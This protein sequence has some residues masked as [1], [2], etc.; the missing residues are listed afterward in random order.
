MIKLKPI[1][2]QILQEELTVQTYGQLKDIISAIRTKQKVVQMWDTAKGTAVDAVVDE[3][4]GKIPG[5]SIAKKTFD[6]IKAMAQKPDTIKTKT[7]LDRLD[8]DDDISK[9]LDDTVEEGFLQDLSKRIEAESDN[10]PI[11]A[12]FNMNNELRDY[13]SRTYNKRTVT[14]QEI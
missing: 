14:Y 11:P 1:A 5:G 2:E 3:L 8:I 10:T 6:F 9:I 7:W 12:D 4:I 13:L